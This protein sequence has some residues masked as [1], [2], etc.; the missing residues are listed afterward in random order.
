MNNNSYFGNSHHKSYS[1]MANIKNDLDMITQLQMRR[2]YILNQKYSDYIYHN[3]HFTLL[4]FDINRSKYLQFGGNKFSDLLEDNV[5]DK[6]KTIKSS[7]LN[8]AQEAYRYSF[9]RDLFG[10]CDVVMTQ[11]QG[12]Y[13]KMGHYF[14]KPF[15]IISGP[16]SIREITNFRKLFYTK[17]IAYLTPYTGKITWQKVGN[18]WLYTASEKVLFTVPE[19]YHGV[20]VWTPHVSIVKDEEIKKYNLALSGSMD[21]DNPDTLDNPAKVAQQ[22]QEITNWLSGK[23]LHQ[24]PTINMRTDISHITI[25]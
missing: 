9:G 25:G 3:F 4:T 7:I 23:G 14:T 15:T 24:L 18:R 17:L 20:G 1:I 19:Y 13:K 22:E 21:L 8:M 2:N 16:E 11:Q 5:G 6:Y 12:V 10:I